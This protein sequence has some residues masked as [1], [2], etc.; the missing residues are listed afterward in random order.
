[1]T[2]QPS[3]E[4]FKVKRP[5][6]SIWDIPEQNLDK[7]ISLGGEIVEDQ[8]PS[9][10]LQQPTEHS[11]H[12]PQQPVSEPPTLHNQPNSA[13]KT[14]KVK[15][16]DGSIWDIPEQNLKRA[17]QLG[18]QVVEDDIQHNQYTGENTASSFVKNI[19]AGAVGSLPD[20]A[21]GISNMTTTS[22][23]PTYDPD[24]GEEFPAHDPIKLNVTDK[25]SNSIDKATSGYTKDTGSINKHAGRFLGSLFG[26][27]YVG[28]GVQALGA[29]GKLGNASGA[30]EKTG[31][32]VA[33]KLGITNASAANVSGA[34]AGGAAAGLSEENDLPA[35]VQI[36]FI[37]GSF[38]LGSKGGDAI[39]KLKDSKTLK[40]LF[41]QVP[42]LQKAISKGHYEDL[43]KNINPEDIK[44]LFKNSIIE[45]ETEFLAEKTLSELPKEIRLKIEKNASL[46]TDSE[47]DLIA[48]KG[49]KDFTNHIEALE[50][51]YFPL[52]TGEYTGSQ[53]IINKEDA[54]ANKANVDNYDIAM[55]NRKSKITRRLEKMKHELSSESVSREEL[56][57]KTAKAVEGIYSDAYKIR[58]DNWN[59]G[60]GKFLDEKILSVSEYHNKLKEFAKLRP[61][62]EGN[63]V[64]INAARSRLKDWKE[65]LTD[66]RKGYEREI[67]PKRFNDILVGLNEE[68][69]RFPDKSFSRK[70]IAELKLALENDL[71][72]NIETA[73]TQEQG[74]ILR[75]TR[76]KYKEDSQIIDQIDESILFS[77]I[78]EES[79]KVPEKI[80][81]SLDNMP[82]SQVRLTFDALKRSPKHHE[83]IPDI[84][85]YYIERALEEATKNGSDSFSPAMFLKRLPKK[86]EF[87]VIF[88]GTNAYQEIKDMSVLLKRLKKFE[89]SRHNSKTE[90]RRQADR[91]DLEHAASAIES[92]AKGDW[93]STLKKAIDIRQ[94]SSYDKKI[95]EIL[96]S[97]EERRNVLS[98]VGKKKTSPMK[99]VALKAYISSQ[100]D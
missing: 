6:G 69:K 35:A 65:G 95:A 42:G 73:A 17:T 58:S 47:I 67:S 40:P 29:S 66:G 30:V 21:I 41:D 37:L 51:E 74:N 71:T 98:Q 24:T 4:I 86:A 56:G 92:A 81:Q 7:A 100:D 20:M 32:F 34:L 19:A 64:A 88:E 53:K 14:F 28:K 48:N 99:A 91:G 63:K 2:M 22:G 60:H 33:N 82:A 11:I 39:S 78:N 10:T 57:E 43:A 68:M 5:D 27:G 1:M 97:P 26:T 18:G 46:L 76:A 77:K 83:I 36:P 23:R 38:I 31:S 13:E 72:K 94:G 3:S 49:M 61:D 79:W 96:I 87:D 54:L 55:T 25:I 62:T 16:P 90:Q 45:K 9:P 59:S 12:P 52:T 85:R 84:Q 80:A 44:G 89:P 93:L 75:N 70:Q 8:A 50:K 15:R